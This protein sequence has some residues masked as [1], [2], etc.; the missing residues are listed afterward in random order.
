MSL[1]TWDLEIIFTPLINTRLR[2]LQYPF[3]FI[4]NK[5]LQECGEYSLKDFCRGLVDE[6]SCDPENFPSNILEY[7]WIYDGEN[8]GEAWYCLCKLKNSC[9]VFYKASCDYTGFDCQGSMIMFISK[10]KEKLFY[11]ALNNFERELCIKEKLYLD[12]SRNS[13]PLPSPLKSGQNPTAAFVRI[14]NDNKEIHLNL[15]AINS[16][17]MEAIEIAV[18][19]LTVKLIDKNNKHYYS[20]NLMRDKMITDIDEYFI[21]KFGNPDKK[22]E[23]PIKNY[24]GRLIRQWGKLE[25][26]FILF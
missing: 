3:S 26:S 5:P 14:W 20:I 2:S 21:E 17:E 22:W 19:K 6:E 11:E 23:L 18:K 4:N 7:Y 8:D 10:N 24:G 9:Y 1:S 16:L 12:F 15:R 25:A 13:L